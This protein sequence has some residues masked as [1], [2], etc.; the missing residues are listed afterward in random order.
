MNDSFID[1]LLTQKVLPTPIKCFGGPDLCEIA[2]TICAF[3]N[4][5]GGWIVV[6][7]ADE[8]NHVEINDSE[9]I[10]Q[11]QNEITKHIAP[12]PMVYI[13][14][15]TYKG[16]SVVLVTVLKGSLPPY[17]FK[18]KYYVKTDG[19]VVVPSPDRVSQLMRDAFSVKSAWESIVNVFS[20]VESLDIKEM[21][22]VYDNGLSSHRL[23][24]SVDGLT[25][26][27]SELQLADSYEVRNGAV[28]L[29]GRATGNSLPQSR[30][31]IQYMS[32]GKTAEVFDNTLILDG[33]I[34]FL[35]KSVI[36]YLSKTLPRQ[37]FFAVDSLVRTDDY[38]YP[39]D[40]LREA[41]GNALIHRD[42]SDSTSEVT[43]F[44]FSDKIEIT[45][46]GE[47]P[48]K[49]VRGKSEVMPHMSILRNPLM[50]EIFYIAGYME[51]TGRGMELISRR[52][53]DLDKKLPEWISLNG[54][55]TLRIF[56]LSSKT[57]LNERIEYFLR[58]HP[59]GDMFT[60]NEYADFFENRPSKITA[61]TDISAMIKAGLCMKIG[62]GRATKYRVI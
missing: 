43:I 58:R 47:L 37:S 23:S 45:N 52:M 53:R 7:I 15:E 44:I 50:A 1:S 25:S 62:N 28:C 19:D 5:Q 29:F 55:T 26:T 34:F 3:L 48:D 33:N 31:R 12:L 42:Y 4:E 21:D 36:D 20:N 51:K 30:V 14:K 8:L 54:S 24:E 17:T 6:G 32:K 35:M 16:A 27:L 39:M 61:Q 41:L 22:E 49:I 13:Q 9:V 57:E 56:N 10:A 59:K 18:G 40:V 46:P 11:I 2:K 60:K 38:M